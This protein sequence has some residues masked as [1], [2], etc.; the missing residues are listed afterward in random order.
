M[1]A[2]VSAALYRTRITH[3]RRAPVH[4]YFEHRSYSWFVDIDAMPRVP[5]WLRPFAR[6]EAQDHLWETADDTLRGRVDA[7]LASKGI[8]SP[9]GRVTALMH[10][11]VLGY[12]F[13]PLTL[14]WCHD[15]AGVLRYVIAE[16]HN[17]YGERHAY[18]LPPS[19]DQPA[20]VDKKFYVSPFNDVDGHYL[21]SAP[22]PGEHLDVRI[23]L[24]RDNQ[25]AFVVTMRGDRRPAGA[26]QILGLQMTAPL[27]PLMNTISI[28]VQGILLWMRRVPVVPRTP[29]CPRSREKV[30]QL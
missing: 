28:R 24:H 26:R 16:V 1:P 15:T 7:F 29:Q 30:E 14:F 18:L 10:A 13:D 21:V 2:P 3:L 8:E 22:E 4:H 5:F 27:A 9:G 17:T 6:F 11:R 12:V 23:S 25:P 20:M 19:G